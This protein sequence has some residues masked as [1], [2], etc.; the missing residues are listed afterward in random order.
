MP[1]K[2][3]T[4]F[5]VSLYPEQ[6][7]TLNELSESENLMINR[8]FRESLLIVLEDES[9]KKELI[10]RCRRVQYRKSG[11]HKGDWT[12]HLIRKYSTSKES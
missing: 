12:K 10:K 8:I 9:L 11:L 4:Q 5:K 1:S 2:A 3:M 7:E 6:A